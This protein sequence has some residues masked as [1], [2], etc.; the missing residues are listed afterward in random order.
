[1]KGEMASLL[2]DL[3]VSEGGREGGR[4]GGMDREEE[5]EMKTKGREGVR[6]EGTDGRET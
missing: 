1:M 2:G 3:K 4:V 5:E 6:E